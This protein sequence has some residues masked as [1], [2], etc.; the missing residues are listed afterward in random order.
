M[1]TK[2][3][4]AALAITLTLLGARTMSQTKENKPPDPSTAAAKTEWTLS[5]SAYTYA[6]PHAQV[7][8]NP[9]FTADRGRLHLEARY[10]YESLET[11]SLW[12]GYNL[13]LGEKV[14]FELTPM[15]GGV[16]GRVNGIAPGYLAALTY[17]KL[18]IST[19][20]EF[21]ISTGDREDSFF[22]TWSE[23]G[24]SPVGWFRGGLVVQRTKVY[25]EAFDIQRGLMAGFSYKKVDFVT[26]V[27]N[28]EKSEQTVVTAV[29]WNF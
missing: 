20:G 4:L 27:F 18:D 6:V 25:N 22:Y 23:L 8:V 15:V 5:A 10:N 28:L 2:R 1:N 21:L 24:Y 3:A 9:N 7:Y 19:Q 14:V 26:Y 17:K 16:F 12:L 11:G 13:S 29:V